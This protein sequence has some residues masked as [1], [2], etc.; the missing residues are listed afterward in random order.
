MQLLLHTGLA[1]KQIGIAPDLISNGM[2]H[3]NWH[4]PALWDL[5]DGLTLCKIPKPV[6]RLAPFQSEPLGGIC[7]RDI[8]LR[9]KAN[10][11]HSR[12]HLCISV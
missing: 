11:F 7:Q 10:R 9:L 3:E 1:D 2:V 8:V 5:A 6:R 4:V 12:K